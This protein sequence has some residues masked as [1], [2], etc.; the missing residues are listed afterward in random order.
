MA[1]M[2]NRT[3]PFFEDAPEQDV[4][5]ILTRCTQIAIVGLSP[6]P[7]RASFGVAQYLQAHGYRIIPI[8]P[9]AFEV[10]GEKAYTSLA[11]AAAEH[12]I[13]LVDVFR[14]S[15]E[16][17]PVIDEAIAIGARAVWL[18]LG[19]ANDEAIA[20]AREAGLLAVQ[21][22]CTKIEHMAYMSQGR[23]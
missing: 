16:T 22:R 4:A 1:F 17:T 10:L 3:P 8:N 23:F 18:Q 5:D 2:T 19:I 9:N 12:R 20:R 15:E 7:H 6:K 21:N 14:R 13:D 11:E